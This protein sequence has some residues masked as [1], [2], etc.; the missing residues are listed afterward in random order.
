M[1]AYTCSSKA[2]LHDRSVAGLEHSLRVVGK[3]LRV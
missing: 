2:F 1:G 3:V